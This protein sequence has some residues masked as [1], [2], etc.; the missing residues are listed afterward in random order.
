MPEISRICKISKSTVSRYVKSV[1]ILPEHYQR[2]LDRRN[3]SKIISE[4][5]W[6]MAQEKAEQL[7]DS[8]ARE[9]LAFIAASLY[10]AEGS[11]KDF[12]LSNTD[13]DLIKLFLYTLRTAFE[14]QDSDLKISVRIYEDLNKKNCLKFWSRVTGIKLGNDTSVN[15]LR[16]KKKGKLSYGMCRVRVK[17][18]GLLLKEIFCIIKR[19][20][21]LSMSS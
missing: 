4:R 15:V 20:N 1:D 10:W 6:I 11:K 5:H 19:L 17:S 2:W 21:Q 9:D 12:G 8:L 3:A 18:G 13:P 7:A 16:G 14:V